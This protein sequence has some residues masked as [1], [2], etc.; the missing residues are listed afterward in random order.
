MWVAEGQRGA[1]S[2]RLTPAEDFLQRVSFRGV[3][4]RFG[5][6]GSDTIAALLVLILGEATAVLSVA[7]GAGGTL[8]GYEVRNAFPI[9]LAG[10]VGLA[11]CVV[12]STATFRAGVIASPRSLLLRTRWRSRRFDWQE[13][14]AVRVHED[15]PVPVGLWVG[16]TG[17]GLY[18][19]RGTS[20]RGGVAR[21]HDGTT[22]APG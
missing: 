10:L 9:V 16:A 20:S 13:V 21:Q 19:T 18:A 15:E 4:L 22:G 12:S 8:A 17:I 11:W 6:S 7:F 2:F 14:A 5:P 1:E 3:E